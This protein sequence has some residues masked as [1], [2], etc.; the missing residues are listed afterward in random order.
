MPTEDSFGST[1]I[2]YER[3]SLMLIPFR[4]RRHSVLGGSALLCGGLALAVV[5]ADGGV[6]SAAP[7]R[8]QPAENRSRCGA[9]KN[10][11]HTWL[12]ASQ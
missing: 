1:S 11:H 8:W 6:A 5:G 12:Q 4:A 3:D 9:R 7:P 2:G 10:A